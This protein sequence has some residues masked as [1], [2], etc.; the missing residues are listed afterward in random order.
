M[1]PVLLRYG[2]GIALRMD[3]ARLTHRALG[4]VKDLECVRRM[5]GLSSRCHI[6]ALQL[7]STFRMV[8]GKK[9]VPN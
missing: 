8:E 1:G 2:S 3:V 4:C 5:T 7:T 6:S 9:A